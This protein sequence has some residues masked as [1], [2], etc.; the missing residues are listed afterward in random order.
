MNTC[1]LRIFR[2]FLNLT[3]STSEKTVQDWIIECQRVEKCPESG[4]ELEFLPWCGDAL[5]ITLNP[6][7]PQQK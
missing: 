6:D 4:I 2:N 3:T 5:L 1:L 7:N